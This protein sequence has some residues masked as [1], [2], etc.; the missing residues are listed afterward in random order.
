VITTVPIVGP[1]TDL[2]LGKISIG[3][4][5]FP[6]V[7]NDP[8]RD[9]MKKLWIS[10]LPS[11]FHFSMYI[12]NRFTAKFIFV[13]V[14]SVVPGILVGH[15]TQLVWAQTWRVG[16]GKTFYKPED[17]QFAQQ[18]YICNYGV[19]GNL[20][21]SEMYIKGEPCSECPPGTTCSLEYPG[22]C[23]GIPDEPLTIRPPVIL[24]EDFAGFPTL[25]SSDSSLPS[26]SISSLTPELIETFVVDPP[27]AGQKNSSCINK[28]KTNGGC[29]VKIETS[30]FISGPV[31]GSC[32]PPDF[33][34]ECSGIPDLC[35]PCI[36]ICSYY[37]GQEVIIHLDEQGYTQHSQHSFSFSFKKCFIKLQVL[38]QK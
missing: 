6:E 36:H 18:M 9:G 27:L 30:S 22:L 37:P 14:F 31:L 34:G 2:R 12:F 13:V 38:K 33:G 25:N 3:L 15:Y 11:Y 4:D 8:S 10:I 1:L 5:T 35:Q 21:R 19:A 29:S 17:A 32:F 26:S 28:C 16:C 20:I 23:S 24:P 7:G